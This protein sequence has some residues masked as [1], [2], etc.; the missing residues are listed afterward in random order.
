MV[1]PIALHYALTTT[2]ERARRRWW[3]CTATIL[4]AVPFSISRTGVIAMLSVLLVL[5]FAWSPQ[6]RWRALGFGLVFLVAMRL[7]VP[8]LVGTI[9]ALFTSFGEDP[10][11]ADRQIDYAFVKDLFNARPF[12]GRGF[13]TFIPTRYD[14]LDNQYLMTAVETGVVGV[15]AI[16]TLFAVGIGISRLVWAVSSDDTSRD[17]ARS[18][19]AALTV[20]V[21]TFATFD[22]MSFATS[23]SLL[24]LLVGCAGA[25]WRIEVRDRPRAAV[26][27]PAHPRDLAIPA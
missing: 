1:F 14:W 24:F 12:F 18:L 26:P 20:P 9:R 7:A 11:V 2:A 17:L 23:R 6:R 15:L 21:T 8:G 4:V 3:V 5:G 22:Y 10:S 19:M 13:F 16:L 27:E 25:L